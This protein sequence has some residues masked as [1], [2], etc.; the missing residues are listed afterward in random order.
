MIERDFEDNAIAQ[1]GDLARFWRQRKCPARRSSEVFETKKV[2]S[3][4]IQQGFIKNKKIKNSSRNLPFISTC[5]SSP[6]RSICFALFFNGIYHYQRENY[7]WIQFPNFNLFLLLEKY[8][9]PFICIP[10]FWF[11]IS[12][13]ICV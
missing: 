7:L 2:F 11:L 9:Y 4:V 1:Q 12:C 13:G 10:L 8:S 5:S 6:M 3:E